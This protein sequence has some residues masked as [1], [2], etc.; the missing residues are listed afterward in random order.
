MVHN[1][2]IKPTIRVEGWFSYKEE[3][4][5]KYINNEECD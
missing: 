5:A 3:D 4:A 1:I 2:A